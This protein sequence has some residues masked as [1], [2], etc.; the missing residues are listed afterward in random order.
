[1]GFRVHM[2]FIY[3]IWG[4]IFQTDKSNSRYLSKYISQD[5]GT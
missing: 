2:I 1:M 3:I 5:K 4:K